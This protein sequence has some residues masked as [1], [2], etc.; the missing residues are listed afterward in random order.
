M[1][2]RL[3]PSDFSPWLWSQE[4]PWQNYVI[5][6]RVLSLTAE[7]ATDTLS[8]VERDALETAFKEALIYAG[9]AQNIMDVLL[10]NL[11]AGA[12]KPTVGDIRIALAELEKVYPA[13]AALWLQARDEIEKEQGTA[14]NLSFTIGF[15]AK[16]FAANEAE[17]YH[18][19]DADRALARQV[20]ES[21]DIEAKY[22]DWMYDTLK[23]QL[24]RAYRDI[25]WV[26]NEHGE[27]VYG[28]EW[29]QEV[30]D[31]T[32]KSL[33]TGEYWQT[34][35][36][37]WQAREKELA[38]LPVGAT[39]DSRKSIYDFWNDVTK[40]LNAAYPEIRREWS[41]YNK[42]METVQERIIH[43]FVSLIE[44]SEP[45]YMPDDETWDEYQLRVIEFEDQQLDE[46]AGRAWIQMNN[47][48]ADN[49]LMMDALVTFGDYGQ[50]LRAYSSPEAREAYH[51]QYDN[52]L[53]ALNKAWKE[54]YWEPYWE[55]VE[56][57]SSYT[58]SLE[59]FIFMEQYGGPARPTNQQLVDWVMEQYPERFDEQELLES[60]DD[61]E[62]LTVQERLGE[63][64]SEI[65]GQS[66]EIWDIVTRAGPKK[67]KLLAKLDYP[68]QGSLNN[69]WWDTAGDLSAWHDPEEAQRFYNKIVAA[70]AELEAEG[71][72]PAELSRE[73]LEEFS[74]AYEDY[75]RFKQMRDLMFNVP[76][77]GY[78]D[79]YAL[80]DLEREN[81]N[82]SRA[83][84]A[85]LNPAFKKYY[86]D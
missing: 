79:L 54:M 48:H 77:N 35:G 83:N 75:Q 6:R 4:V 61:G 11:P 10:A 46:V 19:R 39:Y 5:T 17:L 14:R 55:A 81:Y 57:S 69:T 64:K 53:D 7:R 26:V 25:S 20:L 8:E 50:R 42:S 78:F 12:P 85:D 76:E 62:I 29:M 13:G 45:G 84:F 28:A 80:S 52:G 9:A 1:L 30:A 71:E 59:E 43:E 74:Q 82:N 47:S 33:D 49:P 86:Y 2:G 24:A 40:G 67:D 66:Q 18:I 60:I 15:S 38:S 73:E 23:G 21:L 56:G 3:T 32:R 22:R 68:T 27:R 72:L 70:A 41:P 63:G 37:I 51:R 44:H 34:Y 58:R 16:R 36:Q 31:R 65:W